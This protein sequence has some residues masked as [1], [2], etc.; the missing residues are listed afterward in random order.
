MQS[1]DNLTIGLKQVAGSDAKTYIQ[2]LRDAV[3]DLSSSV[4]STDEEKTA[5]CQKL[6]AS[7]KSTMSDQC[8]S[9]GVFNRLLEEIR[10]EVLPAVVQNY[11][12][13]VTFVFIIM[14]LVT[15]KHIN[16]VWIKNKMK[17]F[18]TCLI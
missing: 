14:P 12:K 10:E 9:N 3:D 2:A 18:T 16:R 13:L 6:L 11:D 17:I 8:A 4:S 7:I 5:I 1:G 15:Y